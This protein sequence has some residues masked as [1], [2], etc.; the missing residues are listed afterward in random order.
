MNNLLAARVKYLPSKTRDFLF[1]YHVEKLGFRFIE[2]IYSSKNIR[3]AVQYLTIFMN[4]I[5]NGSATY[6]V[7]LPT[8][9][10][11]AEFYE[12]IEKNRF[13]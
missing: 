6:T 13:D 4:K 3:Y 2:V 10:S 7:R 11:T 12:A 1:G 8:E 9:W 5:N